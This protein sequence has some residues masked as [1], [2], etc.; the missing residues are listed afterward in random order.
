MAKNIS[1]IQQIGVGVPD[2][3]EAWN[4]YIDN[5]N[6][7]I[8]VFEEKA[9][10]E[11][12]LPHT[13][14]KARERYAALAINM[15]GGGGFEIWQHTGKKPIMP[16]TPVQLGDLGI[17][18]VKMKCQNAAAC[19]QDFS[20]KKLEILGNIAHNPGGSKHFFVKD[21]YGNI[22]EFIEESE[23]F[24][25]RHKNGGVY[26]AIIGVKNIEESLQVYQDIL[27][28]DEI[29]Y[30]RKGRFDD[31]KDIPGGK[32]EV[33]RVLLKHSEPRTGAFAP[34]LGP[35]QI[36]LVEVKSRKPVDIFE[37]RIW[38][39]PGFIHICFDV[40]GMD[41]LREETKE[42]GFP[43]T[44][45]SADSFDMGEAAGHF[46]Y[47]QAPENTLIEFVETHKVPIAKKFGWY[48]N[49]KK[50]DPH[51]P[52]PNYILKAMGLNKV[53]NL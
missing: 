49:L 44:V 42:K 17:C 8:R 37:G 46:S 45:D 33:R 5:F 51:K 35:T 28:Y 50:R 12:M 24:S 4:W 6:M 38:G 11:L 32:E 10:A 26:G 23:S 3:K 31:T 47:I 53:K 41:D 22:F 13:E 15:E 18:V 20:K 39:D 36:E 21:L 30:D 1:G 16:E 19:Y 34:L 48:I 2:V 27:G 25:K 9:V 40:T 29:V 52:L 43:F 14:G 7:N